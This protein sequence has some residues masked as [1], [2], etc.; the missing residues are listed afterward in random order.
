MDAKLGAK[1]VL[2]Y[3]NLLAV[4]FNDAKYVPDPCH[5]FAEYMGGSDGDHV[6]DTSLVPECRTGEYLRG[7]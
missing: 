2:H 7:Q 4:I 1:G 5:K 3:W 6:Y